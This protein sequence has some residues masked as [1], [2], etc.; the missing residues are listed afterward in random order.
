ML[1]KTGEAVDIKLVNSDSLLRG[2]C[3]L[4]AQVGHQ[5]ALVQADGDSKP[6][7]SLS[8]GPSL[9]DGHWRRHLPVFPLEEAERG[10]V[11]GEKRKLPGRWIAIHGASPNLTVSASTLGVQLVE[12]I[13]RDNF[14]GGEGEEDNC[15]TG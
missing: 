7:H 4:L 5:A 11:G 10:E 3:Q 13:G 9:Q 14:T 6:L 12:R 2:C 15:I 8:Q 1:G